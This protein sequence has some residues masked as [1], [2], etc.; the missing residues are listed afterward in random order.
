LRVFLDYHRARSGYED[1]V[2]KRETKLAT[3]KASYTQAVDRL[4]EVLPE[5]VPLHHD[6]GDKHYV[7]RNSQGEITV[8]SI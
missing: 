5:N 3:A 4:R 1:E 8:S 6:Y 2:E 7:I